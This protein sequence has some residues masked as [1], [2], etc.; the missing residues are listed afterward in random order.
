MERL[1]NEVTRTQK[2]ESLG[3]VAGG[4]AHD[5]NNILSSIVSNIEL[6]KLKNGDDAVSLRRLS[7]AE[8]AA[9]NA[10]SLSEQLLTFS[11][12]GKPV[13][14]TIEVSDLLRNST[15]FALAGSNVIPIFSFDPGPFTILADSG[16]LE[17]VFNNLVINAKQ[18]MP[19]GGRL[20]ILVKNIELTGQNEIPLEG[21]KYV[22]MEFKDEGA[23][24]PDEILSKLF[25]PF[26]TT[27]KEG[28]GLG[29]TTALSIVRNHK[30]HIEV[31][32]KLG[33]GT[34]MTVHLPAC[35]NEMNHSPLVVS[36]NVEDVNGSVLIMDDDEQI[37]DILGLLLEEIGCTVTTSRNGEE[38]I[39][40]YRRAIDE[41]RAFDVVIMDLTI[42]GG[43]GGKEAIREIMAI[44]PDVKAI[45]SSGYSNDP[46]MAN[47][48]EMTSMRSFRSLTPS[49]N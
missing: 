28:K 30:G 43:I 26:F 19:D 45:V 17:Q 5:F 44:D 12:G 37:V 24:I 2:L 18:A 38:A 13:K 39:A 32:S 48:Q 27:K 33:K 15:S 49:P 42:K 9:L 20:E 41:G 3:L 6:V 10:R 31:K 40:A 46:I 7:E 11:T 25:D 1:E 34:S 29:L 22:S 14:E 23:G 16:Q 47:P 8:R 36:Q 21:G 35:G 4:I